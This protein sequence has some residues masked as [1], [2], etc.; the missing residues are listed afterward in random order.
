MHKKNPFLSDLAKRKKKKTFCD[1]T[2]N[3][4]ETKVYQDLFI[5]TGACAGA[6]MV[7]V[8]VLNQRSSAA[9]VYNT[10]GDW[11][12]EASTTAMM[13]NVVH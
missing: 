13:I 1:R 12:R 3:M 11:T 2:G 5:R 4:G 6:A 8:K 7:N 9:L 10:V